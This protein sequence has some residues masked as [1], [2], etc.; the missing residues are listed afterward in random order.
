MGT[1]W[2][3]KL[4]MLCF[5]RIKHIFLAGVSHCI[6]ISV[7]LI[8]FLYGLGFTILLSGTIVLQEHFFMTLRVI[9]TMLAGGA[10]QHAMDGSD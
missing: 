8:I 10:C 9:Y 6:Q 5:T 7:M 2:I 4:N 1:S 3:A